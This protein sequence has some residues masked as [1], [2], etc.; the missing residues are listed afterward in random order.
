MLSYSFYEYDNRV[1]RYAET[2]AREGHSVD[3][4]S[5]SG[6]GQTAFGVD[7]LVRVYR[8]QRRSKN[9]KSKFV[10]LLKQ[11][12]F[13]AKS[14][15]ILS[16]FHLRRRYQVVHVHNVPDFLVFATLI[17]KLT[18]SKVILDI[19]D[20]LPEFYTSKFHTNDSSLGYR[21]LLFIEKISA[22]WAD[23]VILSNHLWHARYTSRSADASK[24]T[25]IMNY[26]DP[27]VFFPRQKR[28]PST[29]FT[30]IYPGTLNWHQGL[31]VAVRGFSILS[32]RMP[33][34][35][36]E[37]YGVG[38]TKE[39][40]ANLVASLQLEERIHFNDVLP[41]PEIADE[42]AE[43][44][45]GIVP[46]RAKGFGGEA[47]STKIL[48]FMSLGVPVVASDTAIDRYYFDDSLVLFFKS[49][50]E[51][52]LARKM[53]RMM[54][55]AELR[56]QLINRGLEYSRDN[57]WNAKKTLYLDLIQSLFERGDHPA[58]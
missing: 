26:P 5:L 58:A 55:D 42:M 21:A 52:D 29:G 57:N 11:L 20:I 25:V 44:S 24:C 10:H 17:P 15:A 3:V 37:I 43:A 38:E 30:F 16:L 50:D 22:K 40:L 19:H 34:A 6:P 9:E 51:E 54:D 53:A 36:F 4:F 27:L 45:C 56:Q 7:N 47:F 14:F 13:L 28:A 32:K 49:E 8:I 18:G 46:K 35:R 48:E 41:F 2:L 23:R 31:D 39:D 1:R 12:L 33:D